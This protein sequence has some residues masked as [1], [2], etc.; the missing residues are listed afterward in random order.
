MGGSREVSKE[1]SSCIL[2]RCWWTPTASHQTAEPAQGEHRTNSA[3]SISW[4]RCAHTNHECPEEARA[5]QTPVDERVWTLCSSSVLPYSQ[6]QPLRK[7]VL[8]TK[9]RYLPL[10]CLFSFTL[11]KQ[12]PPSMS[13]QKWN[14]VGE[15]CSW[16]WLEVGW[17]PQKYTVWCPL[18]TTDWKKPKPT[19]TS[20]RSGKTPSSP[21]TTLFH[22]QGRGTDDRPLSWEGKRGVL[23]CVTTACVWASQHL[24]G[25]GPSFIQW[26]L[27]LECFVWMKIFSCT[28]NIN[29]R[30]LLWLHGILISC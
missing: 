18:K 19:Q 13:S 29:E 14:K 25:K 15:R 12:W 1:Q 22:A 30:W 27:Y 26:A 20:V 16:T 24:S 28:Y 23:R 5:K 11:P 17:K 21:N 7:R 10:V 6:T 3:D 8:F 4:Y 2:G 9:H